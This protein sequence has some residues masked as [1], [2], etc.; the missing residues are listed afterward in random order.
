MADCHR[1]KPIPPGKRRGRIRLYPRPLRVVRQRNCN[2]KLGLRTRTSFDGAG[3][4]VFSRYSAGIQQGHE[5]VV[6]GGVDGGVGQRFQICSN[7]SWAILI[8]LLLILL[9][10]LKYEFSQ[11][12]NAF[13][14][15]L[16]FSTMRS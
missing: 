3:R 2:H 7:D 13:I 10:P 12:N 6:V 1:A 11:P 8:D 5:Q 15:V 14:L 9:L 4:P 16:I